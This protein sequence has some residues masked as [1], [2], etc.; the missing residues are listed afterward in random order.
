M[1]TDGSLAG[2]TAL[3]TGAGRGIG[4]GIARRLADH[5]AQ[6]VVATR[7]A[8]HGEETVRQISEGGGR[9]LLVLTDLASEAEIGRLVE[10]T[11]AR[12]GAL[13]I[14]VHNAALA[15]IC[16]L[17][18]ITDDFLDATFTMNVKVAVW[19]TKAVIDPMRARGGGRILFTSSV[20]A[21]HA[22][23]GAAAYA[24]TKAGLNG[25]IRSAALELA[26]DRIT[27]NG[28]EPGIIHTDA[29]AKHHISDTRMRAVLACIPLGE[30]GTPDDIGDAM[31]YLAGEG[32]RY[33]TGQTIVIDGG[34]ALP[35]N[36]GF[37]VDLGRGEAS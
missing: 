8:R 17:P 22:F 27:V 20:T 26:A 24:T 14:A 12:F 37:F 29:L 15:E 4:R 10:L 3:V 5:G 32:G 33:V 35:E 7:T 36:G 34:M 28:V 9:A 2:R 23:P 21:N 11:V 13:D 1:P 25:F 18:D 30:L 19:L 31:V 6:V 16:Y